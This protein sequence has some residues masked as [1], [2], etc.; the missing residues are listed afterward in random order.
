MNLD[1][2]VRNAVDETTRAQV[3]VEG[4]LVDL[5]RTRR[6]RTVTK[7]GA[8]LAA[9]SVVVVGG[10][11]INR[12]QPAT[13]EPAPAPP[14]AQLHGGAV[15]AL[16]SAGEVAQVAGSPLPHVPASAEPQGPLAFS[17]D[18]TSLV[19]AVDAKVHRLD[20]RTGQDVATGDCPDASCDV[21]YSED[22]TR[23]ATAVGR[24]IVIDD[25]EKPGSPTRLAIGVHASGLDWS[26][27]SFGLAYTTL[28]DGRATL[29]VVD[30]GT[31]QIRRLVRLPVGEALL[32]TPAWS[33]SGHQIAFVTHTGRANG[34]AAVELQTVTTIGD[35]LVTPLHRIG[36]CTC[37]GYAPGIAWSPDDNRL[38]VSVI[39]TPKQSGGA[40][41][42]VLRDGTRW[43]PQVPGDFGS[44]ITWQPPVTEQP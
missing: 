20:L 9:V 30:L 15:L 5:R 37:D 18:G 11:T 39:G 1:S 21:A 25:A 33:P 31:G 41:W 16:N 14:P 2:R 40:I 32:G 6:H 36:Q 26:P 29:E 43:R 12:H 8:A 34:S 3:D 13:P 28:R 23:T 17:I 22:L 44:R 42:S 27:A 10:V 7:A 4:R 19:Y 24:T 38:L 35:P